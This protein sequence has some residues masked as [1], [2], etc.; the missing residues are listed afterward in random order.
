[1]TPQG[2][3]GGQVEP[4]SPVVFHVLLVLSRESLHGYGIMKRAEEDSGIAM[5]PGTVYG[6]I[7]RLVEAG[8]VAEAGEAGGDPRRG[9]A[10]SITEEGL[11]ALRAEAERLTRL[12]RLQEVRDL[13]PDAAG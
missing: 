13:L 12:A 5:G 4:L 6:A 8:W 3:A 9:R 1:M 11:A 7:D 2:E 10:F